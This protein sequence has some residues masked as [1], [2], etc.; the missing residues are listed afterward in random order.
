[1]KD[2]KG[3][4][5]NL[6]FREPRRSSRG[7]PA[8]L[9]ALALVAILA[10][11]AWYFGGGLLSPG[12]SGTTTETAGNSASNRIPLRLPPTPPSYGAQAPAAPADTATSA[13][14]STEDTVPQAA[15]SHNLD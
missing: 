6:Q 5:S 7:R 15:G 13:P 3:R 11:A 14:P 2:Y 4:G 10:A 8:L 9:V 12:G 1:M